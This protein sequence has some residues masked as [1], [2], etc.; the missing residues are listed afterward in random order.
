MCSI[1]WTLTTYFRNFENMQ[2]LD[3]LM[4][5]RE[6]RPIS[7][8]FNFFFQNLTLVMKF[9]AF[10]YTL[11]KRFEV[12]SS[13]LFC[14]SYNMNFPTFLL[15]D[16]LSYWTFVPVPKYW[17]P[18]L[19]TFYKKFL[20]FLM[21]SGENRSISILFNICPKLNVM[22]LKTFNYTLIKFEAYMEKKNMISHV[23]FIILLSLKYNV[24]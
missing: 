22:K 17:P 5:S 1:F 21:G 10:S 19:E 3:F 18:I 16:F 2:F 14:Y 24:I 6:N 15:F 11:I 13:V 20:D 9:K 23:L 4:N 8:V 7:T 12:D